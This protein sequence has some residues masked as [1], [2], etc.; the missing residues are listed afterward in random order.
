MPET[1]VVLVG[2]VQAARKETGRTCKTRYVMPRQPLIR[3]ALGRCPNCG[4]GRLFSRYLKVV[5][6]CSI[7]GESY[8]HFRADDAPPWLTILLVGHITVPIIL[9]IE[10][11]VN[12][13]AWF[14]FAVYP[15]IVALLT[16][17]L[18][19][20]CKGLIL[21]VLWKTKAE[22]SEL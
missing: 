15:P 21:A 4:Y 11:A 12:P 22:G 1:S 3:G 19:P 14:G 7:C 2:L 6:Q 17:L 20:R 5:D 8:G 9:A 13:P 18:L 10:R 16:L